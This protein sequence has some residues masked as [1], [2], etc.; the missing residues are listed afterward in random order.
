MKVEDCVALS[1]YICSLFDS[2]RDGCP[3]RQYEKCEIGA[4]NKEILDAAKQLS[5]E[6][7]NSE[8]EEILSHYKRASII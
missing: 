6:H 5:K 7:P 2:C 4:T 8:V 3:F 1:D